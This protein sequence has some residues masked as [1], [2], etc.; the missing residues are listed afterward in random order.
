M[1][2]STDRFVIRPRLTAL[3]LVAGGVL[4]LLAACSSDGGNPTPS[5][6]IINTA[7]GGSGGKAGA[8]DSDAGESSGGSAQAARHKLAAPRVAAHKA[9]NRTAVT[10]VKAARVRAAKPVLRRSIRVARLAISAS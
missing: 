4:G 9:A 7:G 3:V 1:N 2:S 10:P 6:P 8:G 5:N